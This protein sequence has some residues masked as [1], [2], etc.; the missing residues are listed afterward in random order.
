[1]TGTAGPRDLLIAGAG[2]FARETAQA[3]AAVNAAGAPRWRLLGHLDDDPALHGT[4]VDGVPV[5][6]GCDLVHELPDA[7]VVLCVGSPRDHTGRVRLARRLGLPAGRWATVVHPTASVSGSS[8]VGPGSVLLAQVVLTA[9]VRLGAHVAVMPHTVLTHDDEVADFATLAAGVRLAGGVRVGR[10]AYLGSGALVREFTAVGAWSLVGMGSVV[11][12][13]VPPGEVWAG[14]PARRLR[15]AGAPELAELSQ[16]MEQRA[17][18]GEPAGGARAADP[19]AGRAAGGTGNGGRAALRGRDR[20]A[21]EDRVRPGDHD[22]DVA[23]HRPALRMG[24]PAT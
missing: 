16:Q 14:T 23:G 20:A 19:A 15:A 18:P 24:S 13:D 1:V 17:A 8:T 2:G 7:Q 4:S 21:E 3:V 22:E 11:L 6:G 10:G 12:G 5:L 9:A